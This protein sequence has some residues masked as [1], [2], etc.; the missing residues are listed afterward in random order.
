MPGVHYA[1]WVVGSGVPRD[2]AWGMNREHPPLAKAL[3]GAAFLLDRGD[4][5]YLRPGRAV[6]AA[7]FAALVWLTAWT[8]GALFGGSAGLLAGLSLLCMPQVLAHAHLA[9]LD[10]PMALAWMAAAA[11]SLRGRNPWWLGVLWGLALL[12]KINALVLA[13][14]LAAWALASR[15]LRPRQL[16]IAGGVG[17]LVFVLGWPWLWGDPLGRLRGYLAFHLGS[18]RWVVP[19]LYFGRVYDKACAPWHYPLVMLA[20]TLPPAT[21]LSATAGGAALL[22]NRPQ[23]WSWLLLHLA[24]AIVPS[25]VPGTPKYDGVRLF[26]AAF[27]FL[28]VLAGLGLDLA[29]RA[30]PRWAAA[31]ILLLVFAPTAAR[32]ARLDPCLLSYYSPAV[33]GL[34]G[35]ERLG[36]ET[37]FWGDAVLPELLATV[38]P[39]QTVGVAPM[40]MGYLQFLRA[41]GRLPAAVTWEL[42]DRSDALLLLGRRGMLAPGLGKRFDAGGGRVVAR[43]GVVLARAMGRDNPIAA[44]LWIR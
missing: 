7:L 18:D 6:S 28:A 23:G 20:I 30:V 34:K 33:G 42:P 38:R 14:P 19:T 10:L 4:H 36:M 8:G 31:G 13:A 39:G 15:G 5:G 16:L 29:L 26:L 17:L 32:I 2:E 12:T 11:Y 25:C 43:E 27:P 3:Y 1:G 41:D 24:F 37:T 21:L 9:A 40:D 35:A 22:R 44:P